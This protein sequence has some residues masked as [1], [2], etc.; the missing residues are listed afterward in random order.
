MQ[1][2]TLPSTKLFAGCAHIYQCTTGILFM[3]GAVD[4][5]GRGSETV[6]AVW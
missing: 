4:T 5:E 3:K 6:Q 2:H 1:K